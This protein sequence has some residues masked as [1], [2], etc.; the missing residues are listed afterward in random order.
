MGEAIDQTLLICAFRGMP[1]AVYA[2]AARAFSL[3]A[4][5]VALCAYATVAAASIAL[6]GMQ[7]LTWIV[8]G[9]LYYLACAIV[10]PRCARALRH[11]R[12]TAGALFVLF[13]TAY[14]VVPNLTLTGAHAAPFLVLGWDLL[15]SS[16][17]YCH[18]L[19]RREESPQLARCLFFLFV[20]PT[21]TYSSCSLYIG[22]G[23]QAAT[24]AR[25]IALGVLALLLTN[26][27]LQP[28]RTLSL[29]FAAMLPSPIALAVYGIATFL[30]YYAAHSGLASLQIGLMRQ[31][32]YLTPER[33]VLPWLAKDPLDFWRRWNTYVG[34]WLHR[35][36]FMP[37]SRRMLIASRGRAVRLLSRI[38]AVLA[39][40]LASGLLHDGY[41][42]LANRALSLHMVEL[43]LA[44]GALILPFMLARR[45]VRP[46]SAA[47]ARLAGGLSHACFVAAAVAIVAVWG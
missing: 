18:D 38:G 11:G 44:C 28:A 15:L 10:V 34:S 2:C 36:V 21:L 19:R 41:N 29:D 43:F 6:R 40:L 25:R 46:S 45:L 8:L 39:T 4:K 1:F 5:I 3:R 47:A 20:D 12:V 9:T 31:C 42:Y 35:Y 13:A 16:Y 7:T 23:R 37:L 30:A 24:G 33:Y 14:L 32:G 17:S 22:H 27:V 26:A